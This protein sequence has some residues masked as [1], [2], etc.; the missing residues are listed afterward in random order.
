MD[1][2]AAS[3]D[4]ARSLHSLGIWKLTSFLFVL[5]A[6]PDTSRAQVGIEVS[7]GFDGK[8]LLGHP[9]PLTIRITN[10]SDR[11]GDRSGRP[12]RMRVVSS[13][14]DMFGRGGSMLRRSVEV[15]PGVM[16]QITILVPGDGV[17]DYSVRFEMPE[18][19]DVNVYGR[20][21]AGKR[22]LA[23][24]SLSFPLAPE[25]S[26]LRGTGKILVIGGQ[27][28]QI[29]GALAGDAAAWRGGASGR[30]SSGIDGGLPMFALS[31]SWAPD[32]W[33]AYS[34]FTH[35]IWTEPDLADWP[36]PSQLRALSRWVEF[37]G[38]LSILSAR[39]PDLLEQ[40]ALA[41]L[42][43][44]EYRGLRSVAYPAPDFAYVT[45]SVVDKWAVTGSLLQLE[46]KAHAHSID[47]RRAE[48]FPKLAS[49]RCEGRMGDGMVSI[50]TFD[51]LAYDIDR[52]SV[53][54]EAMRTATGMR[55]KSVEHGDET[56]INAYD[57]FGQDRTGGSTLFDLLVN[58]NVLAPSRG[59]LALLMVG[60]VLLIGPIDYI[61][62]AKLKKLH[63]SPFTLLLYTVAFS[64][65]SIGAT[66]LIF[67]PD[68]QIN[69]VALIDFTESS[70]GSE[71]AHGWLF[72]GIYSPYGGRYTPA[73]R[74]GLNYGGLV[75][76][77]GATSDDA[78]G[79]HQQLFIGAGNQPLSID[80]PFNSFRATCTRFS[81]APQGSVSVSLERVSEA[82]A[83]YEL[84]VHNGLGD[85]LTD[86]AF[87][88]HSGSLELPAIAPGESFS[89]TF[90]LENSEPLARPTR[91]EVK[92]R[93]PKV[94]TPFVPW[95]QLKSSSPEQG[96]LMDWLRATSL[97]SWWFPNA[98][99]AQ[100]KPWD[101]GERLGTERGVLLAMTHA[102][103][104]EDGLE[105]RVR[106][107]TYVMVRRSVDLPNSP[108]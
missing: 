14:D 65:L 61:L 16:R 107:F 88:W 6:L 2:P 87:L 56:N 25:E 48:G 82:D 90:S 58:G 28:R 57:V 51:P 33:H 30:V 101:L 54:L 13:A 99:D 8:V 78:A 11:V 105:E 5:L 26:L 86:V 40:E 104:F 53:L 100:R 52:G 29:V 59:V 1:R 4:A 27:A 38:K 3:P 46:P 106:G 63:W 83:G 93:P 41:D 17:I 44:A 62:L 66:F 80:Q 50:A 89:R 94:P 10:E 75:G 69:R 72:H 79:D 20:G 67:A 98:P 24:K 21:L 85:P 42:L 64:A 35:I 18:R 7:L 81:V 45:R 39:R 92:R 22:A 32:N 36:N 108:Q 74:G 68:E 34:G 12:L 103:P 91:Y 76:R 70:D 43:P 73:I 23:V 19:W 84:V 9:N 15:S 97:R 77:P 49:T 71:S 31:A 96:D 37:G 47:N 95:D 55:G 60:F 102:L